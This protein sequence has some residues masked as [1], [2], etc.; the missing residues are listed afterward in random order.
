[1]A[2][3]WGKREPLVEFYAKDIPAGVIK[4]RLQGFRK[5]IGHGKSGIYVLRKGAY[6]YYVG[7]ASSLR[8]RLAHHIRDHHSRKWDSFDL[9][10]VRRAKRKYLTELETLLIRVVRPRGNRTEPNF[11]NS[12]SKTKQ[13][14]K[15]RAR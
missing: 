15:A 8:N 12:V 10:S 7:L 6:V 14:S 3:T 1:M 9:Y 5:V 13:L 2:K 11:A 4:E